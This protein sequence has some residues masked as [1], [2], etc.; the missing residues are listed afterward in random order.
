M[1]TNALYCFFRN[2][3]KTLGAL[4]DRGVNGELAGDDVRII[5]KSLRTVNRI[6]SP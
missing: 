3:T 6:I 4:V 5:S 1:R 2:T